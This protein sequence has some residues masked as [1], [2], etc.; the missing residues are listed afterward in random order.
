MRV[1]LDHWVGIQCPMDVEVRAM[2]AVGDILPH[3]THGLLMQVSSA[4]GGAG[5]GVTCLT[6]TSG[7]RVT[8]KMGSQG[9]LCVE[10]E[11]HNE[12]IPLGDTLVR[13][14]QGLM[15]TLPSPDRDM[16]SYVLH[17]YCAT[18]TIL[19][20]ASVHPSAMSHSPMWVLY[21]YLSQASGVS[22]S[23]PVPHPV[24]EA[25]VS[26]ATLEYT[27]PFSSVDTLFYVL[28]L[29]LAPLEATLIG[30][31]RQRRHRLGKRSLK[32]KITQLFGGR[33]Q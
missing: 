32:D 3:P 29:L 25:A 6:D 1:G 23:G 21:Q 27:L 19:D 15:D 4:A 13:G 22:G 33:K 31:K 28:P 10:Y 16:H 11:G 2:S 26:L 12:D 20:K 14:I 7:H 9:P 8:S 5:G 30:L 24:R 17:S 18:C